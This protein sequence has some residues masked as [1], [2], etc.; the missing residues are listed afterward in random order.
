MGIS[1]STLDTVQLE[2]TRY[3]LSNYA[4]QVTG[5]GLNQDF[6]VNLQLEEHGP[7]LFEFAVE[8]YTDA[9]VPGELAPAEYIP[10]APQGDVIYD[11]GFLPETAP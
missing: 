5:W 1:I 2:T 11:G 7:E 3:G 8:A 4:F 9:Q 6:S 10:D